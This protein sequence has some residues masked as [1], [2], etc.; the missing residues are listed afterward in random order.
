MTLHRQMFLVLRDQIVRGVHG[1]GD[2]LPSVEELGETFGVSA[3]TIR[4]ALTDLAA[5]GYVE[6]KR[7]V[8]TV[9]R[10]DTPQVRPNANATFMESLGAV[11]AGTKVKVLKLSNSR[12]SAEIAS[13]LEL[14]D[15]S[16]A[17]HAVRLRTIGKLP[18]AVT[19]A[20]IPPDICPEITAKALQAKPMYEIVLGAGVP[21][22]RVIQEFTA[23]AA[24]PLFAKIL[25]CEVGSP[26]LRITRLFHRL[27]G[28]PVVHFVGHISPER[29]RILMD[30]PAEAVNGTSGG[31]IVHDEFYGAERGQRSV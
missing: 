2:L 26:L 29:S 19:D 4:R 21:Y 3:I 16:T 8:G 9:V 18:L 23:I 10:S 24:D 25:G 17:I 27:D 30:I 12:P 22:G 11:N 7:G 1:A 28:R 5:G 13:L 14:K 6:R 31:L 15:N 20:W